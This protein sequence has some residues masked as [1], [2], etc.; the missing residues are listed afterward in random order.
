MHKGNVSFL[1]YYAGCYC[2]D[3]FHLFFKACVPYLHYSQE[4]AH[5][6]AVLC[7]GRQVTAFAAAP[8]IEGN[9]LVKT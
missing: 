2:E 5:S 8:R 6:K 4:K 3:S 7:C 1:E 9:E